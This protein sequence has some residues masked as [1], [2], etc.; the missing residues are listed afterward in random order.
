VEHTDADRFEVV[1]RL[2]H[3]GA[4]VF[5]SIIYVFARGSDLE[6]VGGGILAVVTF[7]FAVHYRRRPQYR[8]IKARRRTHR[9]KGKRVSVLAPTGGAPSG[10]T[11]RILGIVT[12]VAESRID[13][14]IVRTDS[15]VNTTGNDRSNL[16]ALAPVEPGDMFTTL[17]DTGRMNVGIWLL[18]PRFLSVRRINFRARRRLRPSLSLGP[19][20]VLASI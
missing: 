18:D 10:R 16:L 19:G 12:W 14:I 2:V 5:A 17:L 9:L 11:V 8:V 7:S 13:E 15:A 1:F 20:L 4:A 6:Y 3:M